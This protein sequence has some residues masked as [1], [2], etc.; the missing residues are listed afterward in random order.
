MTDLE[1]RAQKARQAQ[2][3]REEKKRRAEAEET[4][5]LQMREAVMRLTAQG[6]TDEQIA[7][8]L[9]QTPATIARYRSHSL[10]RALVRQQLDP[11]HYNPE[12][13]FTYALPPPSPEQRAQRARDAQ[14]NQKR[15]RKG[16]GAGPHMPNSPKAP[17]PPTEIIDP[18]DAVHLRRVCLEMRKRAR[19][20]HEIADD[21][22]L[23]I[24][25][26]KRYIAEALRE[27]EESELAHADLERRLM[28]EQ[29][30]DLIRA[31]YN[32]ARG[33]RPDGITPHPGG[34]NLDAIDRVSRLMT[35][36]AKLLGLDQHPT[37][38]IMIRLQ[39]IASDGAYDIE[40][41]EEIAREVFA[42]HKLPLPPIFRA[43]PTS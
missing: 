40:D 38:D 31:I 21:L 7:E 27:L 37:V 17:L 3:I 23:P 13:G 18:P 33:F 42:K 16:P 24:S 12:A 20:Y 5:R 1:T 43:N 19:T 25:E 30:D 14:R 9:G 15:N 32:G 22:V 8:S 41:V 4:Y 29:V 35:Q 11:G 39:Q 26:V 10:E 6:Y 28:V 36:K 34:P 2:V